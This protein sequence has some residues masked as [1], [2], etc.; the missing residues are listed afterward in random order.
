MPT[1]SEIEL[2]LKEH[3]GEGFDD[4]LKGAVKKMPTRRAALNS[5]AGVTEIVDTGLTGRFLNQRNIE[6]TR[7]DRKGQI[8]SVRFLV[9]G[10]DG[11][12]TAV[13]ASGD[14]AIDWVES[15]FPETPSP[16]I[17]TVFAPIERYQ[18]LLKGTETRRIIPGK[19][20]MAQAKDA[21]LSLTTFDQ[22]EYATKTKTTR[23]DP[24][25]VVYGTV[26][27]TNVNTL[28]DGTRIAKVIVEDLN[29]TTLNANV[30]DLGILNGIS[31]EF[32]GADWL[33]DDE[34]LSYALDGMEVVLYGRMFI[35]VAGETIID[36]QPLQED[37]TS[38]VV[39]GGG[40]IVELPTQPKSIQEA[41]KA[42]LEGLDSA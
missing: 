36:G 20:K 2:A 33:E 14:K 26:V 18:N 11:V 23:F 17:P 38:F 1:E 34:K 3:Y 13:R 39:K 6:A 7:G 40:W 10:P 25:G 19:T 42:A 30:D 27:G 8:V 16:L 29:S 22:L 21:P 37:V 12:P 28:D 5:L 15:S 32:K 4:A 41:V 31:G 9:Q 24:T 35:G